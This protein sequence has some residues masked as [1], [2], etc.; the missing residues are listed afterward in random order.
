[1]IPAAVDIVETMRGKSYA[2]ELLKIPLADK[3]V[4]IR[5]SD[6]SEY[7][8]DTFFDKLKKPHVLHC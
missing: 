5:I 1:V 2:K 7:L 8:C 4:G 3:S 6:I